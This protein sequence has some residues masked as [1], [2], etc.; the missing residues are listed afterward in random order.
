MTEQ[1]VRLPEEAG[2]LVCSEPVEP[3]PM[4]RRHRLRADPVQ[5]HKQDPAERLKNFDEV[6][7]A[8]TLREAILEVGRCLQCEHHPCTFGCPAHNDIPGA[9]WLLEQ[10][11]ED[12]AI[13]KS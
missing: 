1:N 2:H 10:S 11:S 3:R 8:L 4:D 9:L 13:S 7:C 12:S 5:A 6:S